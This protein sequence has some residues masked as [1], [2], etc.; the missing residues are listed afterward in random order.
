MQRSLRQIAA[1]GDVARL[2]YEVTQAEIDSV[3]AKLA[4]GQSNARDQ[5]NALLDASQRYS[6]YL[7]AQLQLTRAT[8]QLMRQTGDIGSWALPQKP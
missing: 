8:M 5:E 1:A 6:S 2:E 3:R 4:S 7:D